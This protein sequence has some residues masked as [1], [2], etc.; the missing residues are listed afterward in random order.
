[1]NER[2]MC[3]GAALMLLFPSACNAPLES[4][5]KAASKAI[6]L[7]ILAGQSNAVGYNHI[8]Q[9]K[10]A[11]GRLPSEFTDLPDVLFWPGSNGRADLRNQWTTLQFGASY[12]GNRAPYEGGCFGPE[13]T[14]AHGMTA[15]MPGVA[16]AIVKFAW[17]GTGIARSSDYTDFI[18]SL[19]GF[20]DQ[21]KNWHPP[22]DDQP[23]G[24]LYA[25]LLDDFQK[26]TGALDRQGIPWELAGVLWMQGEHEA[27]ISRR[28]AGDYGELLKVFI[29]A[30]REDLGAPYLPFAVGEINDHKW[31]FLS[32]ARPLQAQACAAMK[33]VQLVQTRDLDRSGF[34]GAAHFN[35]DSM[36]ALGFRFAESMLNLLHQ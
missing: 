12:L 1:M 4:N 2:L 3:A 17:G 10:D 6:Q 34:G 20:D 27:G 21:G 33:G 29:S 11:A 25:G 5:Y 22:T 31:A 23:A 9:S 13:I 28:M 35:A 14:F 24:D 7:Y 16:I 26:A 30:A 19:T 8:D 32:I 36:L 15:A 18:P